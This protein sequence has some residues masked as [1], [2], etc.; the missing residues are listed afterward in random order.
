M[1]DPRRSSEE[2]SSLVVKSGAFAIVPM[3]AREINATPI[4]NGI[5]SRILTGRV[6]NDAKFTV[7]L[8][9]TGSN[10]PRLAA[11]VG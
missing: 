2:L 10:L 6:V 4:P 11:D 7:R 1:P 5:S 3:M 8:A 9:G